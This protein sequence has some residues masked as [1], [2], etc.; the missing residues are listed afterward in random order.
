[1]NR[2]VTVKS[3]ILVFALLLAIIPVSAS[4]RQVLHIRLQN[5]SAHLAS[6]EVLASGIELRE[7]R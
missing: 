2:F 4:E 7:T 1:M 3:F 5:G 6:V